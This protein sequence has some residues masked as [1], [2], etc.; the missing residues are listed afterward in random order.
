M[1]KT[2]LA[3]KIVLLL[4]LI[5]MLALG[6]VH[7][8]TIYNKTRVD[9]Q[10]LRDYVFSNAKKIPFV[11]EDD[12]SYVVDNYFDDLLKDGIDNYDVVNAEV[13]VKLR[14]SLGKASYNKWIQL[15]TVMMES[16][17]KHKELPF[18]LYVVGIR[19][20]FR[21]EAHISANKVMLEKVLLHMKQAY[22]ESASKLE[23]YLQTVG[24][25]P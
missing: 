3:S 24:R 25:S 18:E 15:F 10:S 9:Y 5:P 7:L 6:I 23:G 17:E 19:T 8:Y 1:R 4:L 20:I 14:Y 12:Y 21:N 2:H 11:S 16:P 13:L 22:P